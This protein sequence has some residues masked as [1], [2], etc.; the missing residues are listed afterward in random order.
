M[1]AYK[2]TSQYGSRASLIKNGIAD[3]GYALERATPDFILLP[4]IYTKLGEAYLLSRDDK[5]AEAS[6]RKAWEIKPDYWRPYV[7]W[8]QRLMQLGKFREALLVAEEGQRN[9][10]GTKSLESLVNDIHATMRGKRSE[11]WFCKPVL[12]LF[13]Q[14]GMGQDCSFSFSIES[15]QK[16]PLFPAEPD[17]A[18]FDWMMRFVSRNFNVLPFGQAVTRL[19]ARELPSAAACIT[20]DDGY[21]DNFSVA[22]PILQRYGLVGTFLSQPGSS[23]EG[24]CGMTISLKA[25]ELRRAV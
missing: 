11:N 16:D 14:G 1:R 5:N 4:E 3:I 9:A 22:M 19:N 18:Q 15:W 21:Q 8:A 7:W 10:L 12:Q 24:G 13:L 25:S 23:M 17:A 2:S 20:F 6:F